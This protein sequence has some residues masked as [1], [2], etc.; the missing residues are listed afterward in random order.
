M[1]IGDHVKTLTSNETKAINAHDRY[2]H[3]VGFAVDEC[4]P[5]SNGA[6][7]GKVIVRFN[8]FEASIRV[9]DLKLVTR[10]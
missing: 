8:D 3:I 5:D 4:V 9:E 2:G 7:S 10:K 1:E 6:S